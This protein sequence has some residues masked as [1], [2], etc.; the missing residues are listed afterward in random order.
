M[1]FVCD[2]CYSGKLTNTT[3][4]RQQ[5]Y[6]ASRGLQP[7]R[8]ES[9]HRNLRETVERALWLGRADALDA[10]HRSHSKT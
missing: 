6:P 3:V 4:H 9:V 8:F 1:H 2:V 7:N 10:E 5:R